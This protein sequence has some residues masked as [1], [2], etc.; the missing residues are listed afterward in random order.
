M[1][2]IIQKRKDDPKNLSWLKGKIKGTVIRK[3]LAL[4]KWK[5]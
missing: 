4:E 5:A 2:I 1:C 3:S